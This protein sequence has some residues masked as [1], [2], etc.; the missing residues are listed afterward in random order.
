MFV[1]GSVSNLSL[2]NQSKNVSPNTLSSL[3][4]VKPVYK[5]DSISINTF[6]KPEPPKDNGPVKDTTPFFDR[7]EVRIGGMMLGSGAILGGLGYLIGSSFGAA[8]TGLAIGAGL[9]IIGPIAMIGY[10]LYKW[11]KN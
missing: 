6:Q 1:N 5:A 11:G 3:A 10:G 4:N 7:P 2:D 8:G 9:G